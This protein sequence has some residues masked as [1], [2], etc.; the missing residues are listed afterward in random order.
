[1]SE[2]RKSFR[3]G[4]IG[5]GGRGYSMLKLVLSFREAEVVAVADKYEDRAERGAALVKE[6]RG[7]MPAYTT[8]AYE[9]LGRDD[10]DAI[11]LFTSW[12]SHINLACIAMERGIAVAMEVGGAYSLNDCHK[13]VA[14][15]EKTRTPFMLLEN[16]CF[17]REELLVTALARRGMFGEIVHCQGAYAHDLRS[18]IAFGRENRHY[19]LRNYM[20]RCAENYPTHELGPI[21]KLLG[22][23]RGNRI[24]SVV[25][26]A[27]CAKG[28]NAYANENEKVD[29]ALRDARFAQGDIVTTLLTCANGETITLRLDT[30]LPRHYNREFTVHG[31]K[32]L[33]EM[34]AN[35][36]FF[37]GMPEYFETSETYR[38]HLDNLNKY[39]EYLPDVWRNITEEEK[40]IGHGGMDGI[41]LRVFI[42]NL[43]AGGE[44]PIDVYDAA[45]WMAVTALSENSIHA[46][47]A[48]QVMPDFTNGM[49][50][51]RELRDVVP[52]V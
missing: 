14:A 3:A 48:P 47:G 44:M 33:Y 38:E 37:D 40:E 34:G 30:T 41:E 25:S 32:G 31:T 46:G 12:E 2:T 22:I 8:D 16:C 43:L 10:L 7:C 28:L 50:L 4:V 18:E 42:D 51:E 52:L 36:V 49:Y 29:P 9:V 20:T 45:T 17:G 35:M 39:E 5:L 27:S 1:M 15:Y 21:A 23:N 6:K 13:L 24:L 26:V 19:R 11:F